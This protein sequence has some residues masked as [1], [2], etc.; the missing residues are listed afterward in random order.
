MHKINY[1]HFLIIYHFIFKCTLLLLSLWQ[2]QTI[3]FSPRLKM[4]L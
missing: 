4:F 2:D 3:P 1:L